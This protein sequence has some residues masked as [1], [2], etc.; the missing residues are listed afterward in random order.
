MKKPPACV[1]CRR[2]KIGCDRVKP[3]CGNCTKSGKNDCFFPDVP[4]AYVPSSS[5]LERQAQSS[6]NVLQH[7][8]TRDITVI[9]AQ[10]SGIASIEQIRDYNTRL[11]LLTAQDNKDLINGS[12]QY[13]GNSS[14]MYND[15]SLLMNYYDTPAIFDLVTSTYSQEEVLIKEMNFLSNRMK[16]LKKIYATKNDTE[17]IK[18][19][20]KK[21]FATKESD[22]QLLKKLQTSIELSSNDVTAS[23]QIDIFTNVEPNF[24]D[25]N[26]IFS[27]F[28]EKIN[29][30][31]K[32]LEP[33]KD[34]PNTT[35]D[36][37]F[38][39]FRDR[40][41]AGFYKKLHDVAQTNLSDHIHMWN[42]VR[43]E[44]ST[45][46]KNDQVLRFPAREV[47][48]NIINRY[49]GTVVE[50]D[51]LIPIMKPK[52]LLSSVEQLFGREPL[53]TTSKLNIG[54]IVTLGYITLCLLLTFESLS[55]SVLIPLKDESLSN[56]DQLRQ[57]VPQ[58]K[59]NLEMVKLELESRNNYS[60]SSDVLRFIALYKYYQMLNSD[61]NDSVDNDEDVHLAR[62]LSLNY[63]SKNQ[64]L[65]M[66][67]NFIYKNYCWRHLY[68]GE[69]PNLVSGPELNSS[70][71]TDPLLN[72]DIALLNFQIEMTKYLHSKNQLI[73]LEKYY[74]MK[75]I[76]KV[77]LNDQ[78][79]RCFTTT[80]II[81]SVVDA[82]IYR[83]SVLFMNYYLLLQY[84]QLE[85]NKKF[86]ET[87]KDFLQLMQETLFYIFSNLASLK[88]AGYEFIFSSRSFTTLDNICHMI[89]GLL[90]R[91]QRVINDNKATSVPDTPETEFEQQR[92]LLILLL[93][94][95]AMLLQDYAKNLKVSNP[96]IIKVTTKITTI[97]EHIASENTF[98]YQKENEVKNAFTKVSGS[99]LVKDVQKLRGISESLIK[100]DFYN[101]RPKFTPV[102]PVS[103]GL[104]ESNFASIYSSFYS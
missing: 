59:S 41:I 61:Y 47:T 76:F 18:K 60:S 92:D 21:P 89:L 71:I 26:Q 86:L 52:E 45:M 9:N 87:Y 83:N 72:N 70:V 90:E 97:L 93:H 32:E 24:L 5:A 14:N 4:G 95:L 2:R 103:L 34:S 78:N 38:L 27:I 101:Q 43:S 15:T 79:K 28:N 25:K 68:R 82:L 22:E 100:S 49:I 64:S 56:F 48:Q 85:D 65:V 84:E 91:F 23:R 77:K 58:L 12:S 13:F 63:E 29:D 40:Y 30:S 62:Q 51:S 37:R 16:E 44:R 39:I 36:I 54:Q 57:W 94:K 98:H 81:H 11:Q 74:R 10:T 96:M 42:K 31:K 53:F 99:E 8:N 66:L 75:E 55:S 3:I 17:K 20:K 73:S 104:T 69:I 80:S 102:D 35:F 50:T 7:Q 67:W 1:Q 46:V 33:L 19:N 88:F 6:Q